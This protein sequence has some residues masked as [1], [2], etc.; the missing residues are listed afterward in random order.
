MFANF[1]EETYR[2]FGY[3]DNEQENK[4]FENYLEQDKLILDELLNKIKSKYCLTPDRQRLV[5][6]LEELKVIKDTPIYNK[7]DKLKYQIYNNYIQDK[8]AILNH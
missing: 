3:P 6:Y 1:D 7:T 2:L 8:N 5:R 4:E